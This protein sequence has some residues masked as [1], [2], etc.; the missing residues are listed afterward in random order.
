M[1]ET[2]VS[3]YIN[4]WNALPRSVTHI[5]VIRDTPKIHFDTLDCVTRAHAH[6]QQAGAACAV[7]RSGAI[8]RDPAEVAAARLHSRR[9]QVVDLNDFICDSALCYPVVGG[10]LVFKDVHHLTTVF[11]TTLGPYL[12]RDVRRLGL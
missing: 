9:I 6:H 2:A 5:I 10:V 7:A 4:A 1:F 11:D 12:L 8:S 3:G